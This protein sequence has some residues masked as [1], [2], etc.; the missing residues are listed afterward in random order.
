MNK[1]GFVEYIK[2]QRAI[3]GFAIV[4]LL[5]F[6]TQGI[7]NITFPIYLNEIG[8]SYTET[9][10]LPASCGLI[11]AFFK[12]VVGKHSD[13]VGKKRYVQGAL[14]ADALIMFLFILAK[15]KWHYV[16]LMLLKGMAEG[17]FMAVRAPLLRKLTEEKKRGKAFGYI[18]AISS[19]G[20]AVGGIGAGF[21]SDQKEINISE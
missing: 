18:A 13:K 16:L 5:Y 14:A 2:E 10:S 4:L 9:G 21:L 6:F 17:T 15:E 1:K 19:L 3:A 8:Y 11:I 7:F 12:V 20:M